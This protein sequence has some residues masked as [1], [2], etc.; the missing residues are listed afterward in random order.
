MEGRVG[1]LSDPLAPRAGGT[2]GPKIQAAEATAARQQS[3]VTTMERGGS[4]SHPYLGERSAL[5]RGSAK[6]RGMV[7]PTVQAQG[8]VGHR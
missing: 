5:P 3:A 8:V 4:A 2:G 6:E 1:P 7:V